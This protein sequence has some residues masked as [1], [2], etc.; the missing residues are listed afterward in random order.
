M[1]TFQ[2][3]VLAS[4]MLL[5]ACANPTNPVSEPFQVEYHKAGGWIPAS[6]LLIAQSGQMSA[7][8]IMHDHRDTIAQGSA[9]L[10]QQ[11][12]VWVHTLFRDFD[13]YKT[14][15]APDPWYTDGTIY[16]MV[17]TTGGITDTVVVYEPENADIPEGLSQI[18]QTM[19]LLWQKVIDEES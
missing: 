17:Y 11:G 16:M 13:H 9:Q 2:L 6:T 12:Q 15:Y 4:G 5:F 8:H 14:Y 19:D 3:I 1:K 18:I 10:S 7:Y